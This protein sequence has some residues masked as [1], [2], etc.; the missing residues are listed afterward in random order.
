MNTYTTRMIH[1]CVSCVCMHIITS[2][3]Y[4]KAPLQMKGKSKIKCNLQFNTFILM[5]TVFEMYPLQR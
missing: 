5:K 3:Y 4:T 2:W 1:T